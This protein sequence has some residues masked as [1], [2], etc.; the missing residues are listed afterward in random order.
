LAVGPVTICFCQR[1]VLI[2][3]GDQAFTRGKYIKVLSIYPFS[4]ISIFRA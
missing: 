4:Q 1:T 2:I 3:L